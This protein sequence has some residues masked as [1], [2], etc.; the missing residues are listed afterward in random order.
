MLRTRHIIS[1]LFT[2]FFGFV[3]L[4]GTAAADGLYIELKMGASAPSTLK[5]SV[6]PGALSLD[7]KNGFVGSLAVG[8]NFDNIR[9]EGELGIAGADFDILDGNADAT[10][11]DGK[12]VTGMVNVYYDLLDDKIITPYVGLGTGLSTTKLSTQSDGAKLAFQAMVGFRYNFSG[13]MWFG[14]EYRYFRSGTDGTLKAFQANSFR[15][16]LMYGF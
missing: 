5:D 7:F 6:N 12:L 13:R 9:I 4:A 16:T 14:G 1:V 11:L 15:A 2:A 3:M 8:L 10:I